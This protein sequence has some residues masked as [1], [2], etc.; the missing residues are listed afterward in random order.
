MHIHVPSD[1]SY[2]IHVML[3]DRYSPKP[4]WSCSS[5]IFLMH[6][7]GF[8]IKIYIFICTSNESCRSFSAATQVW[9]CLLLPYA[10]VNVK[11]SRQMYSFA[12]YVVEYLNSLILC[13]VYFVFYNQ[14]LCNANFQILPMLNYL[15]MMVDP[16][17]TQD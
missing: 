8:K 16:Y 10:C 4:S 5:D 13:D 11:N 17:Y 7:F 1:S 9:K 6:V 2:H 3:Q 12:Y 15:L 14:L